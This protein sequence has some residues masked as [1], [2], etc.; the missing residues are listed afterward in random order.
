MNIYAC[1]YDVVIS[2]AC[3]G[4]SHFIKRAT[5]ILDVLVRFQQF[6]PTIEFFSVLSNGEENILCIQLLTARGQSR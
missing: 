5:S 2:F 4:V 6:P 1:W 3:V